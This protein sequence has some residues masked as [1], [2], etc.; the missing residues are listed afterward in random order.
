MTATIESRTLAI[1][2]IDNVLM[3]T[4]LTGID[5]PL[6]ADQL[7]T[8][9]E[10]RCGTQ[11]I[12]V[13]AY[14]SEHTRDVS[15]LAAAFSARGYDFRICDALTE[16]RRKSSV[17]PHMMVDTLASLLGEDEAR[18]GTVALVT[19]DTDFAPLLA[20][21]RQRG[22]ETI[23]L[24]PAHHIPHALKAAATESQ[25]LWDPEPTILETRPVS[26]VEN[27]DSNLMPG[28]LAPLD[29]SET[30]QS[31]T[32]AHA[33]PTIAA[34]SIPRIG[35]LGE[36][37]IA[38]DCMH[39]TAMAT[40]KAEELIAAC[41]NEF[42]RQGAL[43]SPKPAA[44]A[45]R[46]IV[47][48]TPAPVRAR[49]T[50]PDDVWRLI[51]GPLTRAGVQFPSLGSLELGDALAEVAD[52]STDPGKYPAKALANRLKG[53][54]LGAGAEATT[55]LT[56]CS[57]GHQVLKTRPG[58]DP[59]DVTMCFVEGVLAVARGIGG[60]DTSLRSRQA[61]LRWVLPETAKRTMA[62]VASTTGPAVS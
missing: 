33:L 37:G 45:S 23:V 6:L 15:A 25:P 62:P 16:D 49:E 1:V 58:A 42:A 24:T 41:A 28:A 8:Q 31:Q 19:G 22:L 52:V 9:L 29:Q 7:R 2:D 47:A 46:T 4:N 44:A 20:H 13:R 18:W 35:T 26:G 5:P 39:L 48:A 36:A 61:L 60:I 12:D 50:T 56:I 51:G 32:E 38:N 27:V 30:A 40:R 55:L 59:S 17:D 54:N 43:T 57:L 53:R 14:A 3:G 10:A 34:P 11:A 21:V